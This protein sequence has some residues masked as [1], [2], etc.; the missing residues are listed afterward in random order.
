MYI[1]FILYFYLSDFLNSLLNKR[2]LFIRVLSLVSWLFI[3][4]MGLHLASIGVKYLVGNIMHLSLFNANIYTIIIIYKKI[5]K[6]NTC[7]CASRFL[8]E[9]LKSILFTCCWYYHFFLYFDM[10]I[11]FLVSLGATSKQKV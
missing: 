7:T 6:F 9:S 1:Y 10:L 11:N 8:K 5:S 4:L 2:G 3:T